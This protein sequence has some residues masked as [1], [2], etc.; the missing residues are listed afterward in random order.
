MVNLK[1][2]VLGLAMVALFI[3]I[4]ITVVAQKEESPCEDYPVQD[5]NGN[6]VCASSEYVNP[7]LYSP[8]GNRQCVTDGYR[9]IKET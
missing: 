6:F 5:V 9:N 3:L 2:K 7:F 8:V 1:N 4:A